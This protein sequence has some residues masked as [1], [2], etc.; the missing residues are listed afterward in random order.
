MIEITFVRHGQTDW[1]LEG[2]LQGI[3]DIEL[4]AKGVK[5]AEDLTVNLTDNYDF[6]ISSPLKRAYKTAEI[7]QCKVSKNIES[8]SR[9][10]ERDFGDL[11]GSKSCFVKTMENFGDIKGLESMDDMNKRLLEFLED[12]K[13]R[14]DGRYLIVS[15]GGVIVSILSLLSGGEITWEN[16]PIG[17]CSLTGITYNGEWNIKYC[18]KSPELAD[19]K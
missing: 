6:F 15:H 2:K 14:G 18:S 8:D 13:N 11:A 9:L 16:S 17:N 19:V 1:N 4:N 5:E 7:I 12:I 10:M 3:T